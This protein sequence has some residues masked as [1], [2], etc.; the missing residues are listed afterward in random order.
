MKVLGKH[1]ILDFPGMGLSNIPV[2]I[3]TG[4]YTSTIHYHSVMRKEGKLICTIKIGSNMV[5]EVF[6]EF[7]T[8]LVKSSNGQSEERFAVKTTIR[9][10]NKLYKIELTL[11]K[12]C[13]MK[14]PVLIG[15]KFLKNKFI[16]DVSKKNTSYNNTNK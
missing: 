10:F 13:E 4:A 6:E 7:K 1:D 2:K 14:F 15:R 11:S 3:D 8:R 5:E 16:V 12:R 9:L